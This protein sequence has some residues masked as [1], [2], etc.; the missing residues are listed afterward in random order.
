MAR[1]FGINKKEGRF[2][3]RPCVR[4]SVCPPAPVR[5][6]V[7]PP[8]V[9]WPRRIRARDRGPRAGISGE[10]RTSMREYRGSIRREYQDQKPHRKQDMPV[11][12]FQAGGPSTANRTTLQQGTR[13][14]HSTR[15]ARRTEC[16][17]CTT[18][19]RHLRLPGWRGPPWNGEKRPLALRVVR[20]T[21]A[22]AHIAA[23]TH[24]GARFH[25]TPATPRDA[26]PLTAAA[27][28]EARRPAQHRL[29]SRRVTETNVNA[30]T[31]PN[32]AGRR[33]SRKM[34]RAPRLRSGAGRGPWGRFS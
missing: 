2:L 16:G 1:R 29:I 25:A 27:S 5:R 13:V 8:W 21:R 15:K 3:P 33:P 26:K 24:V 30:K 34:S 14:L 20:A 28:C 23:R 11:F 17:P 22:E 31:N 18:S 10:Y 6:S 4:L 19:Q 12:P 7:Q 9:R 32:A